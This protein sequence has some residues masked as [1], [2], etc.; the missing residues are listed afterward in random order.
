MLSGRQTAEDYHMFSAATAPIHTTIF[1]IFHDAPHA[2]A[3]ADELRTAGFEN[4]QIGLIA[5]G[6]RPEVKNPSVGPDDDDGRW[7]EGDL[8]AGHTIVSVH[9]ADERSEDGR[10]I[11]RKHGATIREPTSVGS[12]GTGLVATPF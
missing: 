4:D 11:L 2:H 12:Y 9:D 7:Y 8:R 5:A 1:G 10:E 3:A 6:A